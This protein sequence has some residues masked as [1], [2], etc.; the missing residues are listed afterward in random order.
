MDATLRYVN[1]RGDELV[2]APDSSLHYVATNMRDFKLGYKVRNNKLQ[3]FISD[4]REF[5]LEA[6]VNGTIEDKNR[7]FEVLYYDTAAKQPG[8]LYAGDYY[9]LCNLITTENSKWHMLDGYAHKKLT[10]LAVKPFWIKDTDFSFVARG[11][12]EPGQS[13]FLDFP[14]D[15]PYD[16]A[17]PSSIKKIVSSS[18]IDA[19][20]IITFDGPVSNPSV[21]IGGNTY[22][23]NDSVGVNERI[24]IDTINR[25][26]SRVDAV[27]GKT[28]I[29]GKFGGVYKE[30]SG[31]FIFQSIPSGET[32]V[33]WDGTFSFNVRVREQRSEPLWS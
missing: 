12:S 11:E 15:F 31:S 7:L 17:Q 19:G 27:G 21:T 18:F 32:D 6:V 2:F 14:Y 30:N 4:P 8:K 33:A 10:M 26:V 22:S 25:T 29:F 28:N 9:I 1:T 24:E 23:V 3:G 16:F 5:T 13:M 20:A